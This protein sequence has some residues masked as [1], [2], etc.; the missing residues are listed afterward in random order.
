MRVRARSCSR[1]YAYVCVRIYRISPG[2][3]LRIRDRKCFETL[4]TMV[5]KNRVVRGVHGWVE[6]KS[7]SDELKFKT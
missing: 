6:D 4:V 7:K 5:A 2:K 1:A 3:S